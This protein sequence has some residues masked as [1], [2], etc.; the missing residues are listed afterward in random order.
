MTACINWCF[1]DISSVAYYWWHK[2]FRKI[3]RFTIY[4]I[5]QKN[6]RRGKFARSITPVDVNIPSCTECVKWRSS[7]T[8]RLLTK[9]NATCVHIWLPLHYYQSTVFLFAHHTHFCQ[10]FTAHRTF[11]MLADSNSPVAVT[12]HLDLTVDPCFERWWCCWQHLLNSLSCYSK[13]CSLL[14]H[15][16]A[17]STV[18][19]RSLVF[20]Y[21]DQLLLFSMLCH[22]VGPYLKDSCLGSNSRSNSNSK[23]VTA[24]SSTVCKHFFFRHQL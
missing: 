8:C 1:C 13:Y 17:P 15:T 7:A 24:F 18:V 6:K 10:V 12:L 9:N 19:K 5:L 4:R 20:T 2:K 22:R 11:T 14:Q 16:Q 3:W 21:W 23:L